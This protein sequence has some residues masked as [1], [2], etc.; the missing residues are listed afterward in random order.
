M[1]NER[2]EGE[3][4][5]FFFF[6]DVDR[7]ACVSVETGATL[8]RLVCEQDL[9]GVVAKRKDAV[10]GGHPYKIRNPDYS[11]YQGRRELFEK[12][13]NAVVLNEVSPS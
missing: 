8:F 4:V 9:E 13:R 12:R 7:A 11:Q 10:Y 1:A 2:L 6:V 3:L 5:N